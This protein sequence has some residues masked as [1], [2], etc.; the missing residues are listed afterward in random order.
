MAGTTDDLSLVAEC[1]AG[2]TDAFG[3]LVERYQ[4]RLYPT[5]LRLTGAVE[6]ALDLLQETFLRAFLKLKGFHGDSSFYTW[7]YR[8]MVNLALTGRRRRLPRRF[9]TGLVGDAPDSS[10]ASDPGSHLDR[11]EREA[12]VQR[13][14]DRLAVDHRVVVVM[15][16]FDGLRYEEIASALG[17]PLGTV[18]SRLHRARC[19]LKSMLRGEFEESDRPSP[20]PESIPRAFGPD[21]P[22]ASS[23]V[24]LPYRG[25]R[26]TSP[27][28]FTPPNQHE[29]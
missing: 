18:R 26:P 22:N 4:D 28:A 6:D 21:D 5:A 3:V 24:I 1:R 16:E 14:L 15:K 20:A 9:K 8:I 25:T 10:E 19:E 2:R 29:A 12:L 23:S 11:A 13:A 27:L 17:V 7:V